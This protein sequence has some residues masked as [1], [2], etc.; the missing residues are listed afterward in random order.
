MSIVRSGFLAL[1]MLLAMSVPCLGQ[2]PSGWS[3]SRR[4]DALVFQSPADRGG[5]IVLVLVPA[6]QSSSDD[7]EDWFRER[8]RSGGENIGSI[9]ERQSFERD[10]DWLKSSMRVER[11]NGDELVVAGFAYEASRGYQ[12]ML[13]VVPAGI[14][15]SDR[16]VREAV[17]LVIALRRTD[18]GGS[19]AAPAPVPGGPGSSSTRPPPPPPPKTSDPTRPGQRCRMVSRWVNDSKMGT[20]C[21]GFGANRVCV[22]TFT[23]GMKQVWERVCD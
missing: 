14:E 19:T 2:L 9:V 23:P 5:N 22:P 18:D 8:L 6:A 13:V 16:R 4:G 3:Q 21:T 17:D 1:L 7:F 11:G 15:E 10:G 12:L 20:S